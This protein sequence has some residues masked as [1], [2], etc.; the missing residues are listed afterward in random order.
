MYTQLKSYQS[1]IKEILNTV[2]VEDK[3]GVD[4]SDLVGNAT[5]FII[6]NKSVLSYLPSPTY[7]IAALLTSVPGLKPFATLTIPKKIS[8]EL[9]GFINTA[10]SL[11]F[12][13]EDVQ[14][15]SSLTDTPAAVNKFNWDESLDAH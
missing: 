10:V 3:Y 12:L 7:D 9:Q 5:R 1:K 11:G 15:S 2:S 8:E 4:P 13:V 14:G 6:V